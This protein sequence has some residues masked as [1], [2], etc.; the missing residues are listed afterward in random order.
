MQNNNDSDSGTWFYPLQICSD[1]YGVIVVCKCAV[2][3]DCWD[4]WL[5]CGGE[6]ETVQVPLLS[7]P[8]INSMQLRLIQISW[9]VNDCAITRNLVPII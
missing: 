8:S 6:M 7:K 1:V 2:L 4:L 5:T 3:C 9:I